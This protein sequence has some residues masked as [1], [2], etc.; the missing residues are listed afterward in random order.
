[1]FCL[2]Y[3][4]HFV[5]NSMQLF[6]WGDFLKSCTQLLFEILT[7]RAFHLVVIFW[8]YSL[9]VVFI[10]TSRRGTSETSE[11]GETR[12]S[13]QPSFITLLSTLCD[14]PFHYLIAYYAG[15]KAPP[16]RHCFP[17]FS[18]FPWFPDILSFCE[19]VQSGQTLKVCFIFFRV[20]PYLTILGNVPPD[21]PLISIMYSLPVLHMNKSN[22]SWKCWVT[23]SI[24]RSCIYP[25]IK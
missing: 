5:S 18:W 3:I 21:I 24:L 19:W 9:Y 16:R 1:M 23:T 17:W 13:L 25:Q 15:H 8:G 14:G 10:C 12:V 20:C 7:W 2:C 4:S 22:I 6:S 11:I